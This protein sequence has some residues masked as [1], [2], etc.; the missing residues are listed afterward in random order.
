MAKLE[1][2]IAT[3]ETT[4][5]FVTDSKMQTISS[6]KEIFFLILQSEK[7]TEYIKTSFFSGLMIFVNMI[8]S[9]RLIFIEAR[10]DVVDW[11]TC[12]IIGVKGDLPYAMYIFI[13]ANLINFFIAFGTKLIEKHF[14]KGVSDGQS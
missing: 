7:K 14:S 3:V 6:W 1:K 12:D 10:K 5:P 8:V 2:E 11:K 9:T 4:V 13:L